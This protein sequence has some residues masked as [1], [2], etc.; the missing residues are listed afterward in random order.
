[1]RAIRSVAVWF[2]LKGRVGGLAFMSCAH[3]VPVMVSCLL[4]VQV[5]HLW[6]EGFS[7]RAGGQV[8]R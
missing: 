1:M 8:G 2:Q 7:G 6:L 5:K 4:G 3:F